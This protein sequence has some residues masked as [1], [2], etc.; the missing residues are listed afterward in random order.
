MG[1]LEETLYTEDEWRSRREESEENKPILAN[2]VN[3]EISEQQK[4]PLKITHTRV[5][6]RIMHLLTSTNY[7]IN[8]DFRR[9]YIDI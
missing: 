4:Y 2:Q 3:L 5:Y 7:Y 1:F 8:V 9:N 6:S